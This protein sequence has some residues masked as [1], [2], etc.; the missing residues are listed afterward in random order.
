MPPKA[1]H[2][3]G[4]MTRALEQSDKLSLAEIRM[5]KDTLSRQEDVKIAQEGHYPHPSNLSDGHLKREKTKYRDLDAEEAAKLISCIL[6]IPTRQV[7]SKLQTPNALAP[8]WKHILADHARAEMPHSRGC[9]TL[10]AC[11]PALPELVDPTTMRQR[12]DGFVPPPPEDKDLEEAKQEAEKGVEQK[13]TAMVA[14]QNAQLTSMMQNFFQGGFLNTM[15]GSL[16]LQNHS[17]HP[18]PEVSFWSSWLELLGFP[19]VEPEVQGNANLGAAASSSSSSSS[20]GRVAPVERPHQTHAHGYGSCK[21]N[22]NPRYAAPAKHEGSNTCTTGAG[23]SNASK[24]METGMS[25]DSQL[26]SEELFAMYPSLIEKADGRHA[27]FNGKEFVV[28]ERTDATSKK[29][30]AEGGDKTVHQP[31]AGKETAVQ[32]E[33]DPELDELKELFAEG[34]EVLI[35]ITENIKPPPAKAAATSSA[36]AKATGG[37]KRE[38]EVSPTQ[39]AVAKAKAGR[40]TKKA[41]PAR[42]QVDGM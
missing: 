2:A 22:L 29:D 11:G 10:F 23:G 6:R 36:A 12:L 35:G 40:G 26:T 24:S 41:K 32:E 21:E 14:Q 18:D 37:G 16:P 3:M 8:F 15:G 27:V 7:K 19:L 42:E 25:A 30:A 39:G 17:W 38:K 34:D 13:V 5:V 4:L 31:P 28:L 1:G 33:K 9:P 20:T